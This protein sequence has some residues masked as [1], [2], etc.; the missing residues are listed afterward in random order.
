M[1]CGGLTVKEMKMPETGNPNVYTIYRGKYSI[2]APD[3]LTHYC[4]LGN[5][6]EVIFMGDYTS[7]SNGIVCTLPTELRPESELVFPVCT[8]TT[9][10]LDI[11]KIDVNGEITSSANTLIRLKG[12]TFNISCN[13]YSGS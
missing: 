5:T 12:F 4:M 6:N 2:T 3:G 8:G 1:S 11:M 10:T 7:D 9:G 13:Y